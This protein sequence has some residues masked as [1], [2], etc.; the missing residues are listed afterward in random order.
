MLAALEERSGRRAHELFDVVAGTS[1]GAI[2]ALGL[3]RPDPQSARELGGLYL[4]RGPAIFPPAEP[5]APRDP[6]PLRAELA[7]RLGVTRM[8]HAL[9]PAVVVSCDAVARRPVVFRGGGLDPGPVG[10]APMARAALASSAMPGTYP[11]VEHTGDDGVAR[12]CVDGGLVANDPSLVAFAEAAALAGGDEVLLVSLGTGAGPPPGP[13]PEPDVAALAA[14]A[15]P[16]LVRAALARALGPLYVRL[17][18]PLRFGA[19]RAFDDGSPANLEALRRTAEAFVA[20]EGAA[21]DTLA[22]RLAG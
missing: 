3:V 4:E 6:A 17:Q 20:R 2:L 19:A 15:A 11:A 5:G 12:L 16:E 7:A 18:A 8:S 10:D 14:A 22:R 21:L 9:V 1:S 13:E